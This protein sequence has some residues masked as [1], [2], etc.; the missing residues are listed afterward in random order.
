MLSEKVTICICGRYYNL[1]TD[2][3]ER[4]TALAAAVENSINEFCG[5]E[6]PMEDGAILTA[7]NFAENFFVA[8]TEADE[9]KSRVSEASAAA[10]EADELMA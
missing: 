3:V 1:K 10:A 9:M 5:R 2:D 4:L 6:R 8:K 7:L